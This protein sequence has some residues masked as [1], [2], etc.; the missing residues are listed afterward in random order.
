[1]LYSRRKSA[2]SYIDSSEWPLYRTQNVKDAAL[3]RLCQ[4]PRGWLVG[5]GVVSVVLVRRLRFDQDHR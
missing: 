1:V 2:V 3:Y 4:N 5:F